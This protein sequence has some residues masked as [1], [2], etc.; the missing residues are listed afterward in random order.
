MHKSSTQNV[1]C[2]LLG[3][4]PETKIMESL[5]ELPRRHFTFNDVVK[6]INVNRKRAYEILHYLLDENFIKEVEKIKNIQFYALNV[7]KPE[8]K[9]LEAFF[10]KLLK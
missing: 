1:F 9:C 4:S 3:Y 7:R 10:Q 8:I 5:L 2:E 6:E